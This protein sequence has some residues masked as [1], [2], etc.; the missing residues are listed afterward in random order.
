MRSSNLGVII[1]VRD[2]AAAILASAAYGWTKQSDGSYYSAA[3]KIILNVCGIGKANAAFA[4]GQMFHRIDE[5][6]M[7]G[8][9]GG[10]G[11]EKVGELYLCAEFVEHDMLATT[12]GVEPGVTPF[13]GMTSAVI[14]YPNPATLQKIQEIC[15]QENLPLK[16]GRTLSG[17]Q[18]MHSKEL[19]QAKAAQYGGQLVDMESAAAAKICQRLKKP[20]CALRYITDNADHNATTS[21]Q[22]N[23]KIS[24]GYFERVLASI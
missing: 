3:R 7:F 12:L 2:E 21:W 8:T 4:L 11:Q 20:F 22:E 1:A 15:R 18:F 19:A 13:S 10:L 24:A 23:V 9:S 14:S 16:T 5:V 6:I 17:D